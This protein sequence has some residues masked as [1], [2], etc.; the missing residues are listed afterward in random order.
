[1]S[2]AAAARADEVR[3]S[4]LDGPSG[5]AL[6]RWL[7]ENV[8]GSAP[9]TLTAMQAASTSNEMWEVRDAA[10]LRWALRRP[11]KVKNAPSAHDVLREFRLIGA[12][13]G[14]DVPHPSP[15]A[16]CHDESLLGAAFYVMTHVDG[17]VLQPPLPD[18]AEV[19][20]E[21]RPIGLEL[22]D[23]IAALS[24]VDWRAQG[25]EGFGKPEGYLDRQ[26]DRWLG[27][28]DRYRTRDIPGLDDLA[29]WLRAQAVPA[30]EPGVLHGDYSIFNVLFGSTAPARLVAIVD[31]ETATIGDPLVDLGW[32]VAQWSEQGEP[33]VLESGI[34]HL[35]GMATRRE[36]VD[37]YAERS[38]R[39]TSSIAYYAALASFKLVCIVEGTYYRF[40]HGQS[41]N[42][43]HAV[44]ETLVP[45]LTQHAL[46]ITR[47]DW[48]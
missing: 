15:V 10:G 1:M 24:R 25:L 19:P 12:L 36:I 21:R 13:D 27:Q 48:V 38:G 41:T 4:P 26:V 5:A 35:D 40:S 30:Q 6:S 46:R 14:T 34:T 23:A 28:L 18:W 3:T 42:P 32:V 2:T 47:G 9:F 37:R 22:V 20:A 16:A 45:D 29:A 31:W 39:D 8:P 44:F 33:P 17:I 11:P 43:K 7:E